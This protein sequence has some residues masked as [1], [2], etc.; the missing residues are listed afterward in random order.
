MHS[1]IVPMISAVVTLIA[2]PG[3]PLW[4][5]VAMLIYH[6]LTAKN[7]WQFS[8]GFLLALIAAEGAALAVSVA[9]FRFMSAVFPD[10]P[11]K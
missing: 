2:I 6:R 4:V 10:L 5:P 9:F 8:L 7:F 11:G 3:A 1:D